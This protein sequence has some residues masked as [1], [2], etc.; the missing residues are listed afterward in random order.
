VPELNKT[1]AEL[2][3]EIKNRVSHRG[4]AFAQLK[5]SLLEKII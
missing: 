5:N 1:A 2:P 4:Q 3:A